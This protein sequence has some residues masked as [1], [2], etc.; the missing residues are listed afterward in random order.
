MIAVRVVE[1]ALIHER[2]PDGLWDDGGTIELF[3][4]AEAMRFS[5]IRS[6][7]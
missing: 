1:L 4:L 5:E 7:T 6:D 3:A 2:G